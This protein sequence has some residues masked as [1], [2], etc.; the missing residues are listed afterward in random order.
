[1]SK[2]EQ[3]YNEYRA[4]WIKKSNNAIEKEIASLRRYMQ[5]YSDG[6]AQITAPDEL[7]DGDRLMALREAQEA[8]DQ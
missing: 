6:F 1:M 3:R 7:S 2:W 8:A 4:L 5:R